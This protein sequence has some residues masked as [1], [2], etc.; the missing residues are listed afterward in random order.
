[1]SKNLYSL[2]S[3]AF[4][5]DRTSCFI[6]TAGGEM[7]SYA[8]LEEISGRFARLLMDLGVEPGDRVAVQIQK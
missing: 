5:A 3:A 2:F 1:M 7:Y 8:M 4:P 6:E